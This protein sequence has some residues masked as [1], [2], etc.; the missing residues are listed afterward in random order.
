MEATMPRM[1]ATAPG[2][3]DEIRSEQRTWREIAKW[4]VAV[5][6]LTRAMYIAVTYG[7]IALLHSLVRL[8][9]VPFGQMLVSWQKWDVHWFQLVAANGYTQTKDAAFF[10]LMPLLMKAIGWPLTP[11]MGDTAYYA[12]GVLVSNVAFLGALILFQSLVEREFDVGTGQRAVLYLALYPKALFTFT[13]YSEGVFLL[14]AIGCMLL[15][16]RGH[17]GWAGVL[18]ALATLDRLAGLALLLPM[19]IEL[20]QRYHWNLGQWIKNGWSALLTAV[21]FAGYMVTLG[22]T[23]GDP[24]AF[25]HAEAIWKRS[26]T[27]PLWTLLRA[28]YNLLN[29]PFGS[30]HEFNR[31]F[32]LTI[33]FLWLG[34]LTWACLPDVRQRLRVP[35]S[36][37]GLGLALSILPLC[38]PL[39]NYIPD[40]ISSSSR[41]LLAAFPVFIIIARLTEGKQWWHEAIVI[42]STAMTVI[43]VTGFVLGYYV[44]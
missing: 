13:A 42:A 23:L 21:A 40:I 20:Y 9:G 8:Q 30:A 18:A 38:D 36:L 16:R 32:D 41:Y 43:F 4:P 25:S 37:L 14:L 10:P 27:F 44:I 22:L 15:L 35:A 5:F 19:A 11:L 34:L 2:G 12:A 17:F 1:R 28:G 7:S 24:L 6:A 26:A 3:R 29:L 33:V 39:I 31:V